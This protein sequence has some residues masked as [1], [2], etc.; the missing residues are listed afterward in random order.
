MIPAFAAAIDPR[1]V[2]SPIQGDTRLTLSLHR[3]GHAAAYIP[4]SNSFLLHGG[5]TDPTNAYS[6]SSAPNTG[7][8]LVL[9]LSKDF[10]SGKEEWN[11]IADGP[12]VAWGTMEALDESVVLFGGDGAGVPV[13]T[14]NDSAYVLSGDTW[15]S[16]TG[17]QPIRKVFAASSASKGTAYI[18]GGEK[19]DGSGFGYKEAWRVTDSGTYDT[20]PDLPT[21]LVGHQSIILSNGTLVLLGGL[22]PSASRFISM[23]TL[24]TLD[25]TSPAAEWRIITLPTPETPLA[26]RG[27]TATLV[28]TGGKDRIFLLGGIAGSLQ[29][30]Q[31]MNDLWVLDV[32][33]G[34]W[35]QVVSPLTRKK[36]AE[37]PVRRY[38]HVSLAIGDQLLVFG[39][40]CGFP[41]HLAAADAC[42]QVTARRDLLML[43]CISLTPPPWNGR[44]RTEPGVS[45]VERNRLALQGCLRQQKAPLRAERT[46][47]R[48]LMQQ[49]SRLTDSIKQ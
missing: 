20:L 14:R 32:A 35:E 22:V 40:T 44:R 23:N 17:N 4:S 28:T 11:V 18:T 12:K 42:G 46:A 15:L 31:V 36:R 25:T 26:R 5:K 27:H 13:Q 48:G 3:W 38:D 10:S 47:R 16:G 2:S 24:Y 34:G 33:S 7:A 45:A 39:G 9:D 43:S 30:G 19:N 49:V 37:Q 29:G 21:D 1:Y 6:Y 8:T 41:R